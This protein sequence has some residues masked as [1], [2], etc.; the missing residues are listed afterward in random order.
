VS[1]R[2]LFVDYSLAG[3][4]S[5][6]EHILSAPSSSSSSKL[7][8]RVIRKVI[9]CVCEQNVEVSPL[10]QVCH[11][12]INLVMDLK[13]N[14]CYSWP[15]LTE[16]I[17]PKSIPYCLFLTCLLS[18]LWIVCLENSPNYLKTDTFFVYFQM[19]PALVLLA[20][21]AHSGLVCSNTV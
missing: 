11:S 14:I 7:K 4:S 21:Q 2:L 3:I 5:D 12:V 16:N 8:S 18:S 9:N 13:F 19:P 17:T 1:H 20:H 10:I 15:A 6:S